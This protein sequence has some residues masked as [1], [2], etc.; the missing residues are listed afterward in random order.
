MFYAVS[1]IFQTYIGGKYQLN[2]P[3]VLNMAQMF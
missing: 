2:R 3:L 1:A